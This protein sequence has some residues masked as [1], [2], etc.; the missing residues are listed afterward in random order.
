MLVENWGQTG[1]SPRVIVV[2]NLS[3]PLSPFGALDIL[4]LRTLVGNSSIDCD[5][6]QVMPEKKMLRALVQLTGLAS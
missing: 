6:F 1:L 3:K 4:I 5:S 2:N